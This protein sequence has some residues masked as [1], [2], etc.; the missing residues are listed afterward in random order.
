MRAP[1]TSGSPSRAH[2]R[3]SRRAKRP[4]HPGGRAAREPDSAPSTPVPRRRCG[5]CR[6]SCR[7]SRPEQLQR[8]PG[9][10]R[11]VEADRPT[12]RIEHVEVECLPERRVRSGAYL[13]EAG[14][15]RGDEEAVV[16]V[17]LELLEL[18]TEAGPRPDERHL[19]AQDVEE[20]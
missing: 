2:R 14:E 20:L 15:A 6:S 19:P 1:D 17:R 10:Q 8:R 3:A 12:L 7:R 4:P 18:V 5:A 16:V 9:E 13:P 11:E